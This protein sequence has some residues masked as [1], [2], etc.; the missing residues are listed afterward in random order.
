MRLLIVRH[1]ES[2]WNRAHRY[3]G[4]QDSALSELGQQQAELLSARLRDEP[5]AAI[6]TSRLQRAAETARAI[7]THHPALTVQ[8]DEALLEIHHGEW[9]GLLSSEVETRF[10]TGLAEWRRYPTRSQMP[11][12][13]SFSNIL[14]RVLDFRDRLLAQHAGQTV[15]VST[16]DVVVKILVADALGMD[17]DR[18]NFVWISNASITTIDYSGDLPFLRSLSDA[19]HL[20]NLATTLESQKAL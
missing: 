6:Y 10:A 8:Q 18:M 20:G 12:G 2:E 7:A 16:H 5:L 14:K 17:M 11:G 19:C 15:L 13:E 9:E 1:G 3:Q 4:Q